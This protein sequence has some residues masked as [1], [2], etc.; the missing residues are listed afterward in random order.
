MGLTRQKTTY[1]KVE[2]KKQKGWYVTGNISYCQSTKYKGEKEAAKVD[3][4]QVTKHLGCHVQK[5]ELL[6]AKKKSL[7]GFKGWE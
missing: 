5:L 2:N 4:D 1:A 6:Q 3:R 7:K